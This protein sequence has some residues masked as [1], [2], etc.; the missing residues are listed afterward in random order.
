VGAGDAFERRVI[1]FKGLSSQ[2][3]EALNFIVKMLGG[4]QTFLS[5][6]IG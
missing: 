3:K 6:S 5:K 2:L 1:S 4:R